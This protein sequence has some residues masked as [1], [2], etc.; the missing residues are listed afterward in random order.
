MKMKIPFIAFAAVA[1]PFAGLT[2][3]K[4]GT[5]PP[6]EPETWLLDMLPTSLNDYSLQRDTFNSPVS[7]R[8]DDSTYDTLEPIGIGCQIWNTPKGPF[9]V[10]VIAGDS[11]AAFHD[12]Q[13]CF[14]AQGWDIEKVT[15]RT[16]K[17]ESHGDIPFTVMKLHRQDGNRYGIYAFRS[18]T[19]FMG[20]EMAKFGWM[21]N[22]IKPGT[23]G[24]GYSYRFIGLDPRATEDD[25]FNFAKEYLARAKESSKG[26]L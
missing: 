4:Y 15:K 5:K 9:D 22:E 13:I 21:L 19:G 7:Y 26:V 12:Q 25:V 24:V 3:Y 14:K 18:P 23:P 11:M 20:Y 17:T 10:V 1:L 16:L 8:M 6:R 2:I